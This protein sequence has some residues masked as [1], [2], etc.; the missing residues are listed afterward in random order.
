MF[1]GFGGLALLFFV[2][3]VYA[4]VDALRRPTD[5]WTRANQN[6]IVWV[7]VILI[8]NALGAAIY[9]LVARPQLESTR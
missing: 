9:L 6:Q 2:L 8:G 4:L 3:W 5:E 1:I 7:L